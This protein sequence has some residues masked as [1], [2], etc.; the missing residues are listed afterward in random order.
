[1]DDRGLALALSSSGLLPARGG[2]LRTDLICYVALPIHAA[3]CSL[4]TAV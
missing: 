2:I 1:M 4:D 3:A